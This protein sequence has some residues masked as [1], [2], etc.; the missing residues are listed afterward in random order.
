M[1]PCAGTGSRNYRGHT[2]FI[3]GKEGNVCLWY[4]EIKELLLH[5]Q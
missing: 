3:K 4:V 1:Y 5:F 2:R